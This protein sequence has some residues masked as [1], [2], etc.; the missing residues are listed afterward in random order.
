M[1]LIKEGK[2]QKYFRPAAML[3]N[4]PARASQWQAGGATRK[5]RKQ[6]I[7]VRD[8]NNFVRYF[9]FEQLSDF[10]WDSDLAFPGQATADDIMC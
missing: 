6:L 9:R 3:R 2:I 5:L 4:L 7:L 1:D 10:F 8:K